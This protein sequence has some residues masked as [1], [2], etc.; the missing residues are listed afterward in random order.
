VE[1]EQLR[2]DAG[3]GARS[4]ITCT[5]QES[6][7]LQYSCTVQKVI[8]SAGST[9]VTEIGRGWAVEGRRGRRGE[10]LD[11]LHSPGIVRVAIFLHRPKGHIVRRINGRHREIAPAVSVVF[12][13]SI[14]GA[15][16]GDGGRGRLDASERVGRQP[17][18]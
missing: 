18:R 14:I 2:G 1:G 8:S 3:G 15:A 13:A 11:H 6:F 16:A 5:P 17:A 7:A 12:G 4:L 9:V 10:E